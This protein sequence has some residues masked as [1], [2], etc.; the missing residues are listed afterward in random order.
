MLRFLLASAVGRGARF[1]LVAGLLAWG[2][3]RMEQALEHYVEWIG[4]GVVAAAGIAY[5]ILRG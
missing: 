4:W 3:P 5:L 2:G 1:Y